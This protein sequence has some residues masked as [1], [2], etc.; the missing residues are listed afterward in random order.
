MP[1]SA[2]GEEFGALHAE[3]LRRQP[4]SVWISATHMLGI[5]GAIAEAVGAQQSRPVFAL[6]TAIVA[7]DDLGPL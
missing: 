7:D 2:F 3:A 4:R 1:E 5:E 6:A